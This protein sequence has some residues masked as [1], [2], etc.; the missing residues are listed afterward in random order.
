MEV[1]QGLINKITDQKILIEDREKKLRKK[2]FQIKLQRFYTDQIEAKISQ[3]LSSLHLS[4]IE[5]TLNKK[6]CEENL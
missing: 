4:S 1:E 6:L 3:E 5:K 2:K